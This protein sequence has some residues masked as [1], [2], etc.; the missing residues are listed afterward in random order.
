LQGVKAGTLQNT[1]ALAPIY[2]GFWNVY[3]AYLVAKGLAFP[4]SYLM[5]GALVTTDNVDKLVQ[6]N[7]DMDKNVQKFPFE[8][9]LVN[10]VAG[11]TGQLQ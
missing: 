5:P 3:S 4:S 9:P 7:S 1:I 6:M 10:I 11:Y 8:L 2:N